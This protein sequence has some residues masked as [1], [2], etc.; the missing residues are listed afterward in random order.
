MRYRPVCSCVL[1]AMDCIRTVRQLNVS[2]AVHGR[3][4]KTISWLLYFMRGL[5]HNYI[6]EGVLCSRRPLCRPSTDCRVAS[7][8]PAVEK[9][10]CRSRHIC[11]RARLQL[12]HKPGRSLSRELLL[13]SARQPAGCEESKTDLSSISI[14]VS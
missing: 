13:S 9:A 12:L 1:A 7:V 6:L 14:S 3:H 2:R 4:D 8:P 5:A 11:F 10:E